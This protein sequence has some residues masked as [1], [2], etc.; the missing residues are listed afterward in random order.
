[1]ERKWPPE[2]TFGA[3]FVVLWLWIETL[4][5]LPPT[6]LAILL[7]AMAV[8]TTAVYK[9]RNKELGNGDLAKK[10]LSDLFRLVLRVYADCKVVYGKVMA[11]MRKKEAEEKAKRER[12]A[13]WEEQ[14]QRKRLSELTVAEW[15]YLKNKQGPKDGHSGKR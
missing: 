5:S 3:V 2:A 6:V 12:L 8:G 1:M 10:I 14:L 7:F 4:S 13:Q 11:P 9:V 15:E